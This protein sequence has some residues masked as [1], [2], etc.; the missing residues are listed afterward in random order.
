[1]KPQLSKFNA[2]WYLL[3]FLSNANLSE[4][5]KRLN[6]GVFCLVGLVWFFFFFDPGHV[7]GTLC[8]LFV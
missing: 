7:S 8:T 1:M 4:E 3:V 2:V 5:L 6:L